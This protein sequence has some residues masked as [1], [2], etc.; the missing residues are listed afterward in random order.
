[1]PTPTHGFE[2]TFIRPLAGIFL[3][4]ANAVIFNLKCYPRAF[5][6]SQLEQKSQEQ[7]RTVKNSQG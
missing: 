4:K 5:S 3:H 7:L 1:M 2:G 6:G